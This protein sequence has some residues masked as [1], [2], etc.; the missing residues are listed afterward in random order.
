MNSEKIHIHNVKVPRSIVCFDIPF[1]P[2]YQAECIKTAYELGDH[3][4][5]TTNVKAS[6]STYNVYEQ[7]SV[8]NKILTDITDRVHYA[9]WVNLN[10]YDYTLRDAWVSIYKSGDHTIPHNHG[11]NTISFCYYVKADEESAPLVFDGADFQVQ[12][13]S[14]LCVMFQSDLVHSV[15]HQQSESER[16]ILAGN[17]FLQN[18][19]GK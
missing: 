16:I 2:E 7:T 13:Y 5:R 18:L 11:E 1:A 9:P 6:M 15:P 14:G 12:P 19:K 10:L 8:Y 17:Y 3:M 4:N